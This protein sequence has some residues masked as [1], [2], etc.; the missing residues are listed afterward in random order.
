MPYQVWVRVPGF[1]WTFVEDPDSGEVADGVTVLSGLRMGWAMKGPLW[2]RQ[3]EPM[4]ASIEVNLPTF[5]DWTS[6]H[7]DLAG[8][9]D[10][11]FLA[12]EVKVDEDDELPVARF[13]GDITDFKATPRVTAPGVI[14]SVVAVDYT[15][16]VSEEYHP[17]FVW[18]DDATPTTTEEIFNRIDGL[19]PLGD[20]TGYGEHSSQVRW[21]VGL[22]TEIDD[23]YLNLDAPLGMSTRDLLD[24]ILDISVWD[25]G[26]GDVGRFVFAPMVIPVGETRHGERFDGVG[27]V[28]PS[29]VFYT[30]DV[31]KA[32]P[33]DLPVLWELDAGAVELDSIEW[34]NVKGGEVA[35]VT[36]TGWG[37]TNQN[38]TASPVPGATGDTVAN[39]NVIEH[40]E[41]NAQTVGDWYADRAF[42]SPW[43]LT[44]LVIPVTRVLK[45]GG[46]LGTVTGAPLQLT[47]DWT[48]EEEADYR[49]ACY[50]TGLQIAN[51]D[52]SVTPDGGS[53]I[54]GIVT[55]CEIRVDDLGLAFE[56]AL[57][58]VGV[59]I[60]IP[61][62]V[63]DV[64]IEIGAVY[65]LTADLTGFVTRV[66]L[67]TVTYAAAP[68]FWNSLD[69][70]G[71]NLRVL[72][73]ANNPIDFDLTR[74]DTTAHTGELFFRADLTAAGVNTF[75]L[76]SG[77]TTSITPPTAVNVWQDFDFVT[78]PSADYA[79]GLTV[80]TDRTG[81]ASTITLSVG[82]GAVAPT[83][84]SEGLSFV[85]AT[86]GYCK[87]VGVPFRSSWS[88][89][90]R[91]KLTVNDN[92]AMRTVWGYGT[93]SNSDT[94][95]EQL[96]ARQL[97][98][99]NWAIQ[100]STDLYQQYGAGLG[101]AASLNNWYKWMVTHDGT[102]AR[103]IRPSA[104][105]KVTDTTCAARPTSPGNTLFLGSKNTNNTSPFKGPIE[106]AYLRNGI[107]SDVWVL[108]EYASW[109]TPGSFYSVTV[110]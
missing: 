107:L 74:I 15:V 18:A 80:P 36:T 84:T 52:P 101:T 59:G 41:V 4:T 75:Y 7:P 58:Q 10:G 71:A 49:G 64:R 16:R 39:L 77:D 19:F 105:A 57:R 56:L 106:R 31:V 14:L 89:S 93:D 87:I 61:P 69:A 37:G 12:I 76:R 34:T 40:L 60:V 102:T 42:T 110:V 86:T 43:Q 9:A 3:P 70:D 63:F 47:P 53:L 22:T 48:L 50:S 21:L 27:I 24:K 91:A 38:M 103:T 95:N 6:G 17:Q 62:D 51:V 20:Q 8:A 66:D 11:A 99:N 108:A 90:A 97:V 96:I 73:N 92:T 5:E 72:D 109:E 33:T 88:I 32:D 83:L 67:A 46:D 79:H 98:N 13:Y 25:S 45:A 23:A 30:F 65:D 81:H 44:R 26:P 55:G 94:V 1:E 35:T 82:A 104:M 2:P 68:D 85:T 29:G 100:N 28:T 54:E 78:I